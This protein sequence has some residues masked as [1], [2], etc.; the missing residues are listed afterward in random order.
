MK[1]LILSSTII[2]SIGLLSACSSPKDEAYDIASQV[3]TGMKDGNFSALK[4]VATKDALI[5]WDTSKMSKAGKRLAAQ[6][7][8]E[9]DCDITNIEE[10]EENIFEVSYESFMLVTIKETKNGLRAT[11][12]MPVF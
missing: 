3:C 4:D 8:K 6:S 12:I 7:A 9:F 1:K 2:L 10:I 5:M 11:D